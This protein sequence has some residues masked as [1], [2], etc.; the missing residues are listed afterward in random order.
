MPQRFVTI[1]FRHLKTDW[2]T[3]RQPR[4][5]DLPFVLSV[6]EHGRN[7]I[8]A[9][10]PLALT[11]GIGPGM[12]VADARAIFPSLEALDDIPRLHE[13][14]LR[15]VAGWCVRYADAV[16][17]DLPDG[18]I[19]NATGC[20]HLWGGEQNYLQDIQ[21]NLKKRGYE[22]RIA[23]ADTI[24]TAW[25][26]SR[27]GIDQSIIRSG[28]QLE[29][30]MPLSSCALRLE[31]E[32]TE[33]LYK[34]GL[35]QIRQFI[36]MPRSALR[37]RFGAGL[38]QRL[39]QALGYE[40][41][42]IHPLQPIEPFRQRLPCLEPIVTATGIEIALARLLEMLCAGLELENKGLRKAVFT[43]FR[44]DNKQQKIEIG[45]HRATVNRTHLFKLFS[46]KISGME[47]GPGLELFMLEALN[48]EKISAQQEKLWSGS[49]GLQDKA[50]SEL[51][52]RLANRFAG[53]NIRRY[54]PDE[55][56]W[57]EKSFRASV[58]LHEPLNGT[59]V[60]ERARPLNLLPRPLRIEVTA[61]VP[62]YPPMLFRYEGKLR[63]IKK[64]D[65]PERIEPEWWIREGLHRDYYAVEDEEGNRYW[66][67]REGHYADDKTPQWFIHGFFP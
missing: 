44:I 6:K 3:L 20:A 17:M 43:G 36:H 39:D 60:V 41:E 61:P 7:V 12:A 31:E 42:I 47:P 66:L 52:D 45:T 34:L 19:L 56:H 5:R 2:F 10:N 4:L 16:A 13:R 57:P 35:R 54:L 9:A 51:I 28:Q 32:A 37:R 58:S 15:S 14:F 40:D 48:T 38:I 22:V 8:T 33:R 67:F 29:A 55:H 11:Q 53:G 62:D 59:W 24:G 21:L 65:G 49:C 46:E 63:S 18:L 64:A 1:W 23:I 30:L 26:V 25:A 27:F 50:L